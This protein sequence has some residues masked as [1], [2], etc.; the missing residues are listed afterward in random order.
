M[1]RDYIYSITNYINNILTEFNILSSDPL[2][3]K[4][5]EV[6]AQSGAAFEAMHPMFAPLETPPLPATTPESPVVES[7]NTNR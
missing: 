2:L 5:E 3:E 4:D 6:D 1:D 7:K